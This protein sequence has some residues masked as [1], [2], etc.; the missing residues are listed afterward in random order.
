MQTLQTWVDWTNAPREGPTKPGSRWNAW[1]DT[2]VEELY[3]YLAVLL[4]MGV[5]RENDV[6]D[7]WRSSSMDPEHLPSLYMSRNRFELL[8]QRLTIWDMDDERAVTH[9]RLLEHGH[10]RSKTAQA[11]PAGGDQH[12][13][14]AGISRFADQHNLFEG[15]V[16]TGDQL[17]SN[18][19]WNHRVRG[20]RHRALFLESVEVA[21][22]N[23]YKIQLN[24]QG[25]LTWKRAKK[26]GE[27][28][29][30]VYM[31]LFKVFGVY[32]QVHKRGKRGYVGP[33]DMQA[34]SVPLAQHQHVRRSRGF[35]RACKGF[36]I[37]SPVKRRGLAEAS[38]SA[39]ASNVKVKAPPRVIWGCEQCDV[40][41][42]SSPNC[43]YLWHYGK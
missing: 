38:A 16:D 20:S 33:K 43:W 18:M 32:S 12:P 19:V 14:K 1:Y 22:V 24:A 40:P 35:C 27:W 34:F 17:R 13:M 30:L 6:T 28:R 9:V 26:Q 36:T 5:H 2:C 8:H 10:P 29:R 7:Y 39:S 3:V 4:Y 37:A 42:C 31:E 11:G 25:P 23:S 41:L 21:C 15:A